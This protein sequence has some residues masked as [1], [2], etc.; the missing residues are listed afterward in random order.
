MRW[1]ERRVGEERHGKESKTKISV[2]NIGIIN[3][4][5]LFKIIIA[6][7]ETKTKHTM[8]VSISF[9][10]S[11]YSLLFAPKLFFIKNLET[12]NII[13]NTQRSRG[14]KNCK[15]LWAILL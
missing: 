12:V 3:I 2:C 10:S 6:I 7:I 8:S 9:I 4:K 11:R 5:I 14:M 1:G 13:V 15:Y